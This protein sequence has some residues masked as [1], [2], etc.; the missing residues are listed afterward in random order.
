MNNTISAE[1]VVR[2][3]LD[4]F[5]QHDLTRAMSFFTEQSTV[6]AREGTHT[7]L[8]AIEQWHRDRFA[9]EVRVLEVKSVKAEPQ[10]ALAELVVTS[11]KLAETR[12]RSV[13]AKMTYEIDNGVI[14]HTE[15]EFKIP[16]ILKLFRR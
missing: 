1:T 16:G 7:G 6:V 3:Y 12:L 9:G 5:T 11:A 8:A 2:Q 15:L 13:S 14:K 10:G 4:A